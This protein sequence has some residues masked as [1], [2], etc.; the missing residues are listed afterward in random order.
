MRQYTDEKYIEV[1]ENSSD[2]ILRKFMVAEIDEILRVKNSKDKTFIDLGAGH[3]RLLPELAKNGKNII[4]IEVNKAMLPELERRT[5]KYKNAKLIQ[6]DIS[7]LSSLLKEEDLHRPVILLLGN[8]LS[9]IEGNSKTVLLEIKKVAQS[10]NGEIII[11]FTL[12][13]ALATWGIKELYP[14]FSKMVGEPDLEKTDFKKGLFVSK[15]GYTSKWRS[16]K[17]IN[18]I[19]NFFDG[20]V[21]NQVW[22]ENWC[23]IHIQYE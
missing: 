20:Q 15:T 3:G 13:E 11:S 23:V 1:V 5:K 22:T 19:I 8:T 16:K 6:G 4:S 9:V 10:H 21:V 12:A 17:E 18:K 7:Q 14:S 2:P